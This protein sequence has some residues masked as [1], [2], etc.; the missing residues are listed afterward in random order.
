MSELLVQFPCPGAVTN[1]KMRTDGTIFHQAIEI[2][3]DFKPGKGPVQQVEFRFHGAR[4]RLIE[5]SGN[6]F[7]KLPAARGALFEKTAPLDP[8]AKAFD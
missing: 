7:F 6:C 4:N 1:P 8:P 3:G 2:G 5:I